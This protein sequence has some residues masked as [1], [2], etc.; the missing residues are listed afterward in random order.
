MKADSINL[1]EFINASKRTFVIPVYQR[2]YD[3]KKLQCLTLFRD[4]E[5]IAHDTKRA[6]H[7]LGTI[8]YI[9][10]EDTATFKEFIV[11]DGQQRLTSIMLLLKAIMERI[12]DEDI[13]ED[14][15]ESCLINKRAP[16]EFRI[17][18]KPMKAD[19]GIYKELINGD[20][21][22]LEE[23][24]ITAN[25][26]YF[27]ELVDSSQLTPDELYMGIQ[28][29][30][31]VYIQ[32]S[33]ENENPQL[34]FESLNSTGLDLTQADLI[35][36]YLLMGQ[37]YS[38]QE[39]LYTKYWVRIEELLPDL[40]ISDFIRDYL[41]LKTGSISNKD[42]VY[43]S[44]KEYYE[45]CNNFEAEG[46]LEELT[47][48]A[49]YYSWFKYCNCPDKDINKRLIQIDNLKSTVVYPFLLSIFEDGYLYKKLKK[50]EVCEVLDLIISYVLRRMVCD[51]PTNALNKVFASLTKDVV[52]EKYNTLNLVQKIGVVLLSKK[53]KVIFPSNNL[54]KENFVN[55]DFYNFKQ[56]RYVLEEIEKSLSKEKVSFD[57]LTIEH[58]MP[59]TLTP[60]WQVALG[61]RYKEIH[62]TNVHKI[63]NLTLTG[64]N[65]EMSN[66]GYEEK[67]EYFSESNIMMNRKIAEVEEWTEKQINERANRLFEQAA[68]IWSFPQIDDRYINPLDERNEFEIMDDV[69]MTKKSPCEIIICGSSYKVDSW[70]EFFSTICKVMY[71]YD[72]Q[73]FRS[74][75]MHNDFKGRKK[76]IITY[77][78]ESLNKSEEVAEGIFIEQNLNAND[79]LNYSKLVVEKYQDMENEI[80]YRIK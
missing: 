63:G 79:A 6:I 76:R 46:F 31:I 14:I 78:K 37:E 39:E 8:V 70:K 58:I 66:R 2:N 32:L 5:K 10:G 27:L 43:K 18:L 42:K 51:L 47:T 13:K 29:L 35:R 75:L 21:D 33:R 54:F 15:Y 41:T 23:S 11:I 77:D 71:E 50:E 52:K 61:K 53:G 1:L 4:I 34:I 67:R 3:W 38:K 7:F 68:K 74:L 80:I 44:F 56:G 19:Y 72:A 73:I 17:K 12:T 36:N 16:E 25:Y 26:R 60:I 30:E 62:E 24:T 65:S 59:Q 48:Y 40:M 49:E 64:Y 69:D 57:E 20:I 45:S 55:K 9:Q 28:K 22:N